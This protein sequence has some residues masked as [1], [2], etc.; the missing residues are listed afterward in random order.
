MGKIKS[1]HVLVFPIP[2]KGHLIPLLDLSYVLASHGLS[3]TILSITNEVSHLQPLLDTA[4]SNA[5]QIQPLILSIPAIQNIEELPLSQIPVFLQSLQTLA[6][7]LEQWFLQ[8]QEQISDGFGFGPPVCM[9]SDIFLGWT[10]ETATKLGIPRVVFHPSGAFGV[11]VIYSLWAHMPHQGVES[12]DDPIPIPDLPVPTTFRKSQISP[13]LR[14]YKS[15]DPVSGFMRHSMNLNS[16]S[17]GTLINTFNDLE[18]IYIDHLQKLSARPAWSVGPLF[19]QRE[20]KTDIVVREKP[21]SSIESV[22]LQ[23]LNSQ[24]EKSVLYICFGSM[25]ILSNKQIQELAAGLEGSQQSFIWVLRDPSSGLPANEYGVL[26]DGFEERI[27]G[28][29]LVIRGWAPQLLILSHSSIGGYLTHCGWNSTLESIASGVPLVTWPMFADQHFNC[30][31]I[32]DYLKI[33]VR[34]CEGATTVPNREDL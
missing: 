32:V 31:L 8:Q 6:D 4:A 10:Q 25:C 18:P 2:A 5:L 26:P 13:F 34:L 17:W 22:C 11:S 30:F 12:D 16:K 24:K 9:I 7:P 14:M 33:G 28:R 21:S 19:L 20:Q 29:G 3:I 1:P 23:W 27:Q 15:S